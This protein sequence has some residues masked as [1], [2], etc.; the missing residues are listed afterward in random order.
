MHEIV[1]KMN[2]FLTC[3]KRRA[4]NVDFDAFLGTEIARYAKVAKGANL[5]VD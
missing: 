5:K 2:A 1:G 3:P 4:G